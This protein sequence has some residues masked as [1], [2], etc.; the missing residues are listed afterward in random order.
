LEKG[1]LIT[2]EGVDGAGK[3]TQMAVIDQALRERGKDS[4]VTFK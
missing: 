4:R 1:K 3:S 2:V